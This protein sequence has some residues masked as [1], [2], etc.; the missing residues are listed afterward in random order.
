VQVMEMRKRVLGAEHPDTL[1]SMA[2]LLSMYSNQ[3]WWKAWQT[4]HQYTAIRDGGRRLRGWMF[5]L[6]CL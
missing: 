3:G 1:T 5:K 2:N 4:S 6:S